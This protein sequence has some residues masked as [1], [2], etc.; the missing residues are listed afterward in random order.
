M[1][2]FIVVLILAF[3]SLSGFSQYWFGPTV[4]FHLADHNYLS[5]TYDT[6]SFKISPN[7][8]FHAG[9]SI[10]YTA[11]N[12]YSV[13]GE[14]LYER[15][16]KRVRNVPNISFP[17]DSKSQYHFLSFPV[18]LR[19]NFGF[20]N[21]PFRAYVGGGTKISFWLAGNGE[22]DLD[23]FQEFLN[24]DERPVEYKIVFKQSNAT[25]TDFANVRA[26]RVQYSL[27]LGTGLNFDL[28]NNSRL[29][30]D[31]RFT[32]GHSN[33]GF[34]GSPDFSWQ[35]EYY[36]NFEY[37]HHLYA[38]SIGYILEYNA[39]LARKGKSTNQESNKKRRR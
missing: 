21:A 10:T 33:M 26:N 5:S 6:D 20:G 2:R 22:I 18:M 17:A 23:Q 1:I 29:F 9:A 34:N 25:E 8:N 16:G 11:N 12:T 27:Q 4:G 35:P 39:Q 3:S 7:L 24:D 15:I 31:F 30:L 28:V 14:I 32:F 13:Y 19:V 36:E 37:R 38:L